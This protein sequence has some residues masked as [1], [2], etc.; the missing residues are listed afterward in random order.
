MTRLTDISGHHL[1]F[2]CSC[3]HLGMV[4]ADDLPGHVTVNQ[5]QRWMKCADCGERHPPQVRIAYA[6]EGA[7]HGAQAH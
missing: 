7:A 3:G 5:V 6:M 1:Y 4:R 2:W